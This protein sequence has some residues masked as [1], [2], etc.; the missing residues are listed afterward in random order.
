MGAKLTERQ[1]RF[2]DFYVQT[3]NAAEAAR[4]AGY[5]ESRDSHSRFGSQVLKKPE[6]KAAIEARLA[7]LASERIADA[8]EILE[9]L[10]AVMRGE[11]SDEVAMNIGLGRGVT[12][13]EKVALKVSSKDR[14]RAAEM[15]AKIHGMFISRQELEISG[16]V[17]VVIHDDILTQRKDAQPLFWHKPE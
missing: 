8:R 3:G 14:L 12:R 5:S 13:A 17:P 2:V 4:R 16:N 11:Y 10:T 9:Y 7:E 6:I 15:L 1:Q